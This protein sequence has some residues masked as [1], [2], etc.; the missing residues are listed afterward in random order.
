MKFLFQF[1]ILNVIKLIK[2]MVETPQEEEFVK[3]QLQA[4]EHNINANAKRINQ[5]GKKTKRKDTNVLM[6][7][8]SSIPL[9]A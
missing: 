6:L 4:M 1:L 7:H 9:F 3:W 8:V 2:T 5:G